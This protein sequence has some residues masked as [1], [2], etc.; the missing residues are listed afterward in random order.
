MSDFA[1]KDAPM[2]T[3]TQTRAKRVYATDL[4]ARGEPMV[5]AMG[6]SLAIGLLMIV[7]ILGL[8]AWFGF[9]TFWPQPIAVVTSKDGK[10]IAGEVF[11]SES[12][13]PADAQLAAVPPESRQQIEDDLGYAE[14]TLYRV[15]N[16]DLYGEDFQ[17]RN[18]YD[19]ASVEYPADLT[20]IERQEWG[21]FVGRITQ[22]SLNGTVTENPPLDAVLAAPGVIGVLVAAVIAVGL[23][24]SSEFPKVTLPL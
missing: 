10:V 18:A 24:A 21:P 9:T 23:Y 5:F 12:F 8:I 1:L 6:G 17:W 7:G 16:Y 3:T 2:N 15:G 19:V 14:R 20:F 22:L 13:K 11:R 4:A